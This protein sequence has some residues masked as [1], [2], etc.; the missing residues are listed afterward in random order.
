VQKSFTN[1]LRAQ[2]EKWLKKVKINLLR[3][4]SEQSRL[5][6]RKGMPFPHVSYRA[7]LITHFPS[8]P[9]AEQLRAEVAELTGRI[10][11]QQ[12]HIREFLDNEGRA[13]T[14]ALVARPASL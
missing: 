9:S 13:S 10:Q 5:V 11:D 8:G 7:I 1:D 14:A 4:V 2:T 6:F 3:K 12:Q